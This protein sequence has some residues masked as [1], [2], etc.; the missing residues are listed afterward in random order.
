MDRVVLSVGRYHE[1]VAGNFIGDWIN[2]NYEL[3]SKEKALKLIKKH[4]KNK[5][6]LDDVYSAMPKVVNFLKSK[7][8]KESTERIFPP[9]FVKNLAVLIAMVSILGNMYSKETAYQK[10]VEKEVIKQE[11][12][13][14][15][16]KLL[17]K[18]I[19]TKD[20]IKKV[21]Q[22]RSQEEMNKV[23][24]DDIKSM[25]SF[26][27]RKVNNVKY[28]LEL[29]FTA[30]PDGRRRIYP[31]QISKYDGETVY[32]HREHTLKHYEELEK[33]LKEFDKNEKI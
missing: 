19:L 30:D 23:L 25:S 29:K 17:G 3:P 20:T 28:P 32:V 11:K 22:N 31:S 4:I 8:A 1:K 24:I 2:K 33:N 9:G 15:D 14:E 16:N 7:K 18:F 12:I 10:L 5:K 6:D 27:L 13:V 21:K 26:K